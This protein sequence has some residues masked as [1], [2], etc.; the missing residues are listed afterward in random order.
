MLFALVYM[1]WPVK[2]AGLCYHQEHSKLEK[3]VR[4]GDSVSTYLLTLC[5]EIH[6]ILVKNNEKINPFHTVHFKKLL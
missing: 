6:S 2:M 1:F 5:L 4:Q 3:V